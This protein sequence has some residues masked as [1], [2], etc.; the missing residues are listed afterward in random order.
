MAIK[1]YALRH[2]SRGKHIISTTIEHPAVTEGL[3]TGFIWKERRR[4]SDS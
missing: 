3:L 2:M 1:G 4:R